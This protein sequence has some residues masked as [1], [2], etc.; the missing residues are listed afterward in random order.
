LRRVVLLAA[1][2]VGSWI[3]LALLSS[4]AA[5]AATVDSS[6]TN[7]LAS[8][9]RA[10]AGADP[11]AAPVTG[12]G[13]LLRV[14]DDTASSNSA[15]DAKADTAAVASAIDRPLAAVAATVS[16]V[17]Q[18]VDSTVRMVT[19]S[20]PLLGTSA[21]RPVS[22]GQ[23]G[24]VQHD[25]V[26]S[27][28]APAKHVWTL[29]AIIGSIQRHPVGVAPIA[30]PRQVPTGNTGFPDLAPCPVPAGAAAAAAGSVAVD[31]PAAR[32]T[33]AAP[34]GLAAPRPAGSW[35][36]RNAALDPSVSPD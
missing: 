10:A 31:M 26:H 16:S 18:P 20:L 29:T 2:V 23:L 30:L 19:D 27:I 15:T 24:T 21:S 33:V 35:R 3:A 12:L 36:V 14:T 11:S 32:A 6:R 17:V 7:L 9:D 13:Q 5:H 25:Q 1:I 8:S 28:A 34:V 22:A 4:T